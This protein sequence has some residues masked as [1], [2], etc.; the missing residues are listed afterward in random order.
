MARAP[1]SAAQTE[2][3]G[4]PIREAAIAGSQV[5]WVRT[6]AGNTEADDYLYTASLVRPT[7]QRLRTAIRTGDTSGA[8]E[9]SWIGGL[10]GSGTTL[11]VNTWTTDASGAV[12]SASLRGIGAGRMTTLAT[13][14]PTMVASSAD[15]GRIAVLRSDGTVGLYS[16]AGRLLRSFEPGAPK[17]VALRKDYL[18]V[19]TK[20]R[21]LEIYN[22]RTGALVRTWLVPAGASHLDVHSGIAVYSVWRSVHALQLTTGKDAVLA[23]ASRAVVGLEIEA[24]GAVY[25]FNR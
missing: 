15:L 4:Q 17:E 1:G 7:E 24:P 22:A 5:A 12:T 9:G 8:L 16:A 6:I 10:V 20:A 19:L 3:H 13:G 23:T 25:A 11:G 21:T 14:K 2:A 18:V